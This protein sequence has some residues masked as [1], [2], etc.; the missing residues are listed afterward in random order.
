[1]ETTDL[2][3][4]LLC[5]LD[6]DTYRLVAPHLSHRPF[7]RGEVFYQPGDLVDQVYFPH[8]GVLSLLSVLDDGSAV[9]T[10]TV[11]RESGVGLLAGLTRIQAF[12]RIIGQ[13]PGVVS[14]IR[15]S[16]LRAVAAESSKLRDVLIRHCDALL[17]HAQQSVACNALHDV[18][19]RFSRWLL[20]CHDR[21]D[22]DE[23]NVTQEFLAAMLGVQR[24]TVTQVAGLL[25]DAEVIRYQRGRVTITDRAGLER[26]AC[27]CYRLVGLHAKAVLPETA[28]DGPCAPLSVA[29]A[30][31]RGES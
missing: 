10:S 15:A 3:N 31:G 16:R 29:E 9:E 2:K 17:A 28:E 24:T 19:E 21:A 27:E 4:G 30:S 8:S 5:A 20:T 26:R 18:E 11:G 22:G 7:D 1:M 14:S 6:A 23:L 25:Q 13:S 12:S